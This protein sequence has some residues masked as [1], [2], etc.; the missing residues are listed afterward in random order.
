MPI[1]FECPI[2]SNRLSAKDD[3]AGKEGKCKCGTAL[4]VPGKTEKMKFG[5]KHCRKGISI[6][7]RHAGKKTKCPTCQGVIT[8][9]LLG[10]L[11][12]PEEELKL[13]LL[14]DVPEITAPA[15]VAE[16]ERVINATPRIDAKTAPANNVSKKRAREDRLLRIYWFLSF[17]ALVGPACYFGEIFSVVFVTCCYCCRIDNKISI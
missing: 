7:N 15:P 11:I 5:C 1:K 8:I 12:L 6:S 16:R 13:E 10:N 9:P 4:I 3:Y 17:I 2:C 14:P